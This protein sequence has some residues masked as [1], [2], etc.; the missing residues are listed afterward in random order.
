MNLANS[1]IQ[2]SEG[3][4]YSAKEI[5][6]K[7]NISVVTAYAKFKLDEIKPYLINKNGKNYVNDDGIEAIR[8]SMD[9][10]VIDSNT[11]EPDEAEKDNDRLETLVIYT[12]QKQVEELNKEKNLIRREKSEEIE[13]LRE[14]L[15]IKDKQIET[16][17]KL[18]QSMQLILKAEQNKNKEIVKT[19]KDHDVELVNT[20]IAALDK[21]KELSKHEDRVRKG[22]FSFLFASR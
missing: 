17:D 9:T 7:L 1:I 12:L 18:D 10:R 8:Q 3:N 19:I 5:S 15:C 21:K 4:L 16:R 2:N 11:I 14:Q 22:I 6:K 13:S 20:L